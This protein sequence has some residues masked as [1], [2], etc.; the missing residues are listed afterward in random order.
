MDSKN[1]QVFFVYKGINGILLSNRHH[2]QKSV[3]NPTFD[4]I[5]VCN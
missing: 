4:G 5:F 2:E 1:S 3:R